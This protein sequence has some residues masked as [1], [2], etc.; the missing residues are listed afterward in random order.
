MTDNIINNREVGQIVD[1]G[2]F[3]LEVTDIFLR[4]SR[5]NID[6]VL[7]FGKAKYKILDS[8]FNLLMQDFTNE[9]ALYIVG[10]SPY[11]RNY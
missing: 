9:L 8:E 2:K 11:T 1:K 10:H 6:F 3:K 7:D 4:R 5:D